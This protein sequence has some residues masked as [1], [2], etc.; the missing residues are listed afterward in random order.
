[1]PSLNS[2]VYT[3]EEASNTY[4]HAVSE[5]PVPDYTNNFAGNSLTS[6]QSRTM[7]AV[8]RYHENRQLS[9]EHMNPAF[10]PNQGHLYPAVAPNIISTHVNAYTGGN[11]WGR[12]TQSSF[13]SDSS[14]WQ[15]SQNQLN[16]AQQY[17]HREDTGS[18]LNPWDPGID[19]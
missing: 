1:M 4:S 14:S 16:T 12:S 7:V 9:Q 11:S 15:V 6:N 19:E 5:P 18:R 13:P 10:P 3:R 17:Q 2:S 8:P